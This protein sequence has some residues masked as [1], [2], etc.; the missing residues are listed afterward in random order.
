MSQRPKNVICNVYDKKNC[1]SEFVETLQT[2]GNL[3]EEWRKEQ[4]YE[5]MVKFARNAR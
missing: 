5:T 1:Y 4:I 2:E 3:T